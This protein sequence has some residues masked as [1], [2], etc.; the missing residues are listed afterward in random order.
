[1]SWAKVGNFLK[2][3]LPILGTAIG[4]PAGGIAGKLISVALGTDGSPE[5]ALK[6]LQQDPDAILKYKLAEL[7][8]NRDVV[9]ASYEAQ[10]AIIE[11]VNQTIRSEHNSHDP[12]VRR[13]RPFYGYAIAIS[14][15]IQ[16]TGFTIMFV[17]VAI[18][19]PKSLAALV[20]QFAVLSGSLLTLW[21]VALA[22]L[23]V[24]VHKRSQDKQ[25]N[26]ESN[27]FFNKLMGK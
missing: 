2:S 10:Q 15:F 19:E 24:S 12:F 4:G 21:G 20:Q 6:V 25:Q 26:L 9:V 1:M 18:T 5:S 8:T 27:G 14:W 7:E 11:T 3:S 16:M 13:W 23:G 22:V 17:Y